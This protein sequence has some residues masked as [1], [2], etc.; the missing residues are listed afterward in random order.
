[1]PIALSRELLVFAITEQ[2]IP[3]H[4]QETD[5]TSRH[6]SGVIPRPSWIP[7]PFDDDAGEGQPWCSPHRRS[8]GDRI[9]S[10]NG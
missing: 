7:K 6:L 5:M 4:R 10:A 2:T 9:E 8:I 3:S 1:V